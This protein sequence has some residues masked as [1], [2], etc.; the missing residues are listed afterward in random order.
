MPVLQ[1]SNAQVYGD[2]EARMMMMLHYAKVYLVLCIGQWLCA[3]HY[4][5]IYILQYICM[6]DRLPTDLPAQ[7]KSLKITQC[8]GQRHFYIHVHVL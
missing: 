3:Y 8:S 5:Y 6:H 1:G 2:P 4:I 7:T